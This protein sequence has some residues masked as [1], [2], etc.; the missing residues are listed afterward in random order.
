[1]RYGGSQ[2]SPEKFIIFH[3]PTKNDRSHGRFL[4]SSRALPGDSH[5]ALLLRMT[6]YFVR[7][8]IK[9]CLLRKIAKLRNSLF[10]S[11]QRTLC[12]CERSVAISRKGHL[13]KAMIRCFCPL[14]NLILIE[15]TKLY[16][17]IYVQRPQTYIVHTV[18]NF[19]I[20]SQY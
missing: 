2:Q 8:R 9:E 11:V 15:K 1:M 19:T 7:N 5:V 14:T 10:S 4:L 18:C 13:I 3:A 12:H 17:I 16:A 20:G 6:E